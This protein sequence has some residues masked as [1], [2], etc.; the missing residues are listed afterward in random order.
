MPE[1]PR[2]R[3]RRPA[4]VDV[5]EHE[6][7]GENQ[8]YEDHDDYDEESGGSGADALEEPPR[9][10]RGGLNAVTAGEAGLRHIG[11]LT[12]R[13]AEGV[14]L[15][16]PEGDRWLVDVEILEDRR[17]PSSGDILALYEAELDEDGELLSYRRLRRYRRGSGDDSAGGVPR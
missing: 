14:T 2:V 10:R 1:K 4:D 13:Q 12:A 11:A 6:R 3:A 16:K 17:I 8:D 7:A 15:V 5:D 9:R